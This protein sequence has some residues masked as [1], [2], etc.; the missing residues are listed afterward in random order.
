MGLDWRL[1]QPAVHRRDRVAEGPLDVGGVAQQPQVYHSPGSPPWVA[2]A[3]SAHG[4]P[5]RLFM[6][7]DLGMDSL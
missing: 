1:I 2:N 6:K 3:F 7:T 4:Q 5:Q